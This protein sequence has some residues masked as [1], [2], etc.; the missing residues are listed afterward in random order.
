MRFVHWLRFDQKT[1]GLY[2]YTY[3]LHK[4]SKALGYDSHICCSDPDLK[5]GGKITM[6]N[7]VVGRVEF[8]PWDVSKGAV[9]IT[10]DGT[11][12]QKLDNW[13]AE[14]HGHPDFITQS[15]DSL[16]GGM[17]SLQAK[18]ILTRFPSHKQYW[19]QAT[20]APIHVIPPGVDLDYFTPSGPK[21]QFVNPTILWADTVRKGVKSPV[22]LLYAM[23]II[24]K[25]YPMWGLKLVGIPPNELAGYAY[26]CGRL[27]LD[28][29]IS[30]PIHP[31]V[32]DTAEFYRGAQLM[33]SDTNEEGSN[34]SWEAEACGMPVVHH[35][36]SPQEIANALIAAM[37]NPPQAVRRDIK[38]T[39]KAMVAAL[40]SS[41][42]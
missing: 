40:E 25:Q 9:N 22:N 24:T 35:R 16:T 41:L 4:A 1:S 28:S 3:S 2:T 6:P 17:Y 21:A 15:M 39:A 7:P 11:P 36:D 13:V 23:K 42:S 38:I 30:W 19:E 31:M 20:D 34:S 8:S 26:F 12:H 10:H 37:D 33:Y 5:G 27:G 14:I 18:A 32:P 29:A